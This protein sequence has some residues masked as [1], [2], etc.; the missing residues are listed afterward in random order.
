MQNSQFAR[1]VVPDKK[2][3]AVT[4]RGYGWRSGEKLLRVEKQHDLLVAPAPLRIIF[5]LLGA[6]IRPI[7]I[8]L[9]KKSNSHISASTTFVLAIKR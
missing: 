7:D 4:W 3:S 6:I 8:Y 9:N 5:G 1:T 2:Q